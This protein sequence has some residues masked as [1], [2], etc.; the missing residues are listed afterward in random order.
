MKFIR[1]TSRDQSA[2]RCRAVLSIIQNISIPYARANKELLAGAGAFDTI[3]KNHRPLIL[4][5][6]GTD[7][8]KTKGKNTSQT[9]RDYLTTNPEAKAKEVVE[10]LGKTGVK[11]NEGLVYAVKGGMKEKKRRK[12]RVAKAAM[13]AVSKPSSNGQPS[14]PS[15]PDA[16]TMIR[17]VKAL[18]EK[19]GGYEKLKELVDALAQ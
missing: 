10:A 11:T 14:K 1:Q 7:M 3:V 4:V 19:A 8:A 17:E 5:R 12:K 16:I 9:I 13:A 2:P 15:K 18:A 6:K